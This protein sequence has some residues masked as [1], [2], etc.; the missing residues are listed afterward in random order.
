[1]DTYFC[2]VSRAHK[3]I[4]DLRVLACADDRDLERQVDEIARDYPVA[5]LDLF[6]DDRLV[7]TFEPRLNETA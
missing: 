7:R 4:A 6:K 5:R 1:M 3:P 2:Y